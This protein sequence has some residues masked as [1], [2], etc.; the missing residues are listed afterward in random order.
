LM[1]AADDICYAS[2]DLEDG[3]EMSFLTY[4][5]VI[6]IL[7][8]VVDFDKIPRLHPSCEGNDLLSRKIAIARG[9][10]INFLIE[11]VVD[12][13]MLH[14]DDLLQG[15]FS[16]E[17]LIGACGGRVQEFIDAAKNAAKE[18]IF[19]NPRK[20]QIEIGSHTKIELLLDAF[21]KAAYNLK[22]Y[23]RDRFIA[24]RHRR[25]LDL[26]GSHQPKKDWS[27]HHSYMH[28]LDFISGMTDNYAV[29]IAR[30][31]GEIIEN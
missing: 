8:L 17:D 19:T 4:D 21:I 3:I 2:I 26:M 10:A 1:E 22:I 20:I 5:E 14:K 30:Q 13:F 11:G 27:L 18:K 29:N 24:S 15:N 28:V 6:S 16:S 12:T 25:I 31:I 9:R 23:E 7:G